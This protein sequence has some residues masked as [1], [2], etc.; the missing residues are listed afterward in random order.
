MTTLLQRPKAKPA[1]ASSPGVAAAPQ[2]HVRR[3]RRPQLGVPQVLVAGA[4]LFNLWYLRAERLVVNYPND[5]QTHRQMVQWATRMLSHGLLPFDHWY[6]HLSLGSPFFVQYQSASAVLAGALGLVIGPNLAYSWTL[7]L[8]LSLWPLCVYATGRLLG[9]GR[10]ESG[11]AAAMSPLIFSLTGR[12]FEHQ[13]YLWLGSGLWS[14]LWAMW[15]LPLAVG[16]SWRFVQERRHLFWAVSFMAATIA[17]H[18]LM[19]YLAAMFLVLMVLVARADFWRRFARAATIGVLALLTTL[20]VTLPLVSIAKWTALNEFQVH[21]S[22]D[23]SYGAGKVLTWLVRGQI[24]DSGRFPILTILVAVGLVWCVTRFRHDQRARLL[25]CM[26]LLSLLLYFGRPTLGFVLDLLPGNKDLLFQRFV[27]GLDLSGLFLAAVGAV[28]LANLAYALARWT[29]PKAL[30]AVWKLRYARLAGSVLALGVT[31]AVLAPAWT[32]VRTYDGYDAASIAYQRTADAN[33]GSAVRALLALAAQRGGGR[34]F[35]GMPSSPYAANPR[36]GY[37]FRIGEIQ[38]YIYMENSSVDAVGFT[39]RG[40]GLMTDP[41]AWFDE[42]NP[43]DY[44]VMGIKYLLYPV[45]K[46]PPV[47][48]TLVES[49]EGYALWTVPTS[50]IFQ[51]VDT[52]TPIPANASDLGKMTAAFLASDLPDRNI[53]PTIAYAGAPAAA[54]TIPVGSTAPRGPAGKV[55]A[56]GDDLSYGIAT[57]TVL[58][59]RTSVVLLKSSYDPGWSVT[60]DGHPARTQMIAPALVGVEVGPGL[61]R[62]VFEYHGFGEYPLLFGIALL[63]LVG[64]VVLPRAWRRA[65]ARWH[66]VVHD[67]AGAIRGPSRAPR[68]GARA[69]S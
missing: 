34:V 45:G 24:Y 26:W 50:G 3:R 22:I 67:V 64:I 31:V 66:R 55:L 47:P 62:I 29:A 12:G 1:P 53:Y 41:E 58:A 13:A 2:D 15:T 36:W 17:F 28:W 25:S 42:D 59:N 5:S 48:A 52:T 10:W 63:T 49:S 39:L 35:A 7:Y 38:A 43:G 61:H 11:L 9:W 30:D 32:Q 19:A 69:A 23:D 37:K 44:N 40:F 60:V 4:V 46:V 20:W 21:T 65:P 14:E 18:F 27:A 57:A 56:V 68:R 33:Q 6:A 8:L 16:F 51:V 54:P